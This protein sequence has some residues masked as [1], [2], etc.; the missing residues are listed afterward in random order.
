MVTTGDV[1]AWRPDGLPAQSCGC[2]VVLRILRPQG[3]KDATALRS[4]FASEVDFRGPTP[5]RVWEAR[6]PDADAPADSRDAQ[7]EGTR[8]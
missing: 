2:R 4:L 7:L 5:G 8:S 1:R 3:A 6:T